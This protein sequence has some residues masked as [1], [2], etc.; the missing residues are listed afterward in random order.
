MIFVVQ[1]SYDMRI[2]KGRGIKYTA[3]S[4][5]W[6]DLVGSCLVSFGCSHFIG[7]VWSRLFGLFLLV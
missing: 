4:N 6:S 5:T 7:L 2:G 3:C 1:L